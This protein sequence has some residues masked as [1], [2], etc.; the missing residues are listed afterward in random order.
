MKGEQLKA[1]GHQKKKKE[2]GPVLVGRESKGR[3]KKRLI[4]Y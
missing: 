1:L 4:I 2:K 3:W